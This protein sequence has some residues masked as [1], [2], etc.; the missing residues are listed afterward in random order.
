MSMSPAPQMLF[1]LVAAMFDQAQFDLRIAL[2]VGTDHR[3]EQLDIADGG[4][5][6]SKDAPLEPA[7]FIEF[8]DQVVAVGQ[9]LDSAPIDHLSAGVI[10]LRWPTRSSRMVP[11]SSSSC[12]TALLIVD[13]VEASERA[14]CENPPR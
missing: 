9:E 11:T 6:E 13:C 4:H 5:A 2:T 1:E 8:D 10:T 3:G 12:L 14:A 7:D